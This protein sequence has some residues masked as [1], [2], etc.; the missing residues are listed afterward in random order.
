MV[1]LTRIY[2]KSGDCG[3]SS[4]GTGQRLYKNE[5][6][7]EAIGTVDETNA[8]V[9]AASN[10][11]CDDIHL[12]LVR[13][14]ND[15]FDVGADL[16]IPEETHHQTS[17]RISEKQ[18]FYLEGRIDAYNAH[19]PPL[20][21]FVLPGGAPLATDL[22]VAR[23]VARRAERAITALHRQ[24]KLNPFLIQYMNRLSDLLFVLARYV[25][26]VL[27]KQQDVLWVPGENR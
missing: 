4:L 14:Q 21:S 26:H 22:H 8:F 5:A 16:C 1:Q 17:L 6:R 15:L 11:A 3:K 19:L 24:E 20:S 27:E 12:L 18:V 23:T 7:F 10:A 9:A 25:N 2:T 13:I